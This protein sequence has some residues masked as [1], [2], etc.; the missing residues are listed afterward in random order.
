ML[1]VVVFFSLVS[2]LCIK[3]A[4]LTATLKK[5]DK[6]YGPLKNAHFYDI[7]LSG[8]SSQFE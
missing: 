7:D 4:Q 3:L 8:W 6:K 2:H 5:R 1:V